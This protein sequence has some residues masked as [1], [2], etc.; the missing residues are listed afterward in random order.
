MENNKLSLN[1]LLGG[2]IFSVIIVAASFLLPWKLVSWGRF[3]ITSGDTLTVVGEAKSQQKTQ[4]ATF[5]AGVSSVNDDKQTA[6]NEVN[7][8]VEAIIEAV[9]EFGIKAEDIKT[10][11]LNVYQNQEQY[12]EEGRQKVRP[13]QWNVSN[14]IEI[15]LRDVDRASDLAGIL[16]K[17]GATNVY[18]P[19][20][21]FEDTTA[22]ETAL[23]A[24]AFKNAHDKA[25]LMANVVGRKLK[26]VRSFSEGYQTQPIGVLRMEAGGGGGGAPT[27]PGSGTV[28]KTVTVV[29]EL[30]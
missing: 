18:G 27:E 4:V 15:K 26:G 8:K 7:R 21:T 23:I 17:S 9:K 2:L 25:T 20:F 29:F 12:Y 3:Q 5:S 19:N 16:T 11:S 24:E 28:S 6:V 1:F 14:T 10:Q 30:E 13:G 22:A